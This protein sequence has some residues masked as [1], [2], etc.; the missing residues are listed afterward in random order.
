[1]QYF[2]NTISVNQNEYTESL[3]KTHLEPFTKEN[4]NIYH[5]IKRMHWD[6]KWVSYYSGHAISPDLF[7]LMQPIQQASNINK[8]ASKN[9]VDI[10]KSI[11][12]VEAN[13]Y[14]LKFH[15]IDKDAMLV[16]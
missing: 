11:N 16:V 6:K 3:E 13:P 9:L 8:T 4:L 5:H 1:M 10:N 7:V 12:K 2:R 15:S 14:G